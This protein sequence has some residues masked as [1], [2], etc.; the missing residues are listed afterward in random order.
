MNTPLNPDRHNLREDG[1]H[2]PRAPLTLT[3]LYQWLIVLNAILGAAG[4][5]LGL[6]ET[7]RGH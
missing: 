4:L 2:A 6:A 3:P 7:A 5:A 1:H